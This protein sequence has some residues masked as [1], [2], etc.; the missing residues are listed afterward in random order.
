MFLREERE[1]I[2]CAA[3][4]RDHDSHFQL[5]TILILEHSC[6]VAART[7]GSYRRLRDQSRSRLPSDGKEHIMQ[8]RRR[9]KQTISLKDRL[10]A[11]AKDARAK[12]LLLQPGAEKYDL[13]KRAR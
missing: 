10:T 5:A 6:S 11:F 1:M 2:L 13:P 7:F 8:G 12:A 3:S 4:I 9:F